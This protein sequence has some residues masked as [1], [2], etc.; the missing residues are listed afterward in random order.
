[1]PK[2][3]VYPRFDS[4]A[5]GYRTAW[6]EVK[7]LEARAH[8]QGVLK[9]LRKKYFPP[10]SSVAKDFVVR[11]RELVA[12]EE[13]T[14]E[15]PDLENLP[16]PAGADSF[17]PVRLTVENSPD[18][19]QLPLDFQGFCIHTLV[20]QDRLLAPGNPALGVVKYAGRFCVFANE[21]AMTEFCSEEGA[22]DRF[23][24]GV[25]DVCYK[26]PELIHLMRIHEDFPKSSLHSILQL[27]SGNQAAMMADA[28]TDTP[29][30][31]QESNIDKNYEWNEWRM[32][33]EALHMADIKRKQTSATQ[34]ALSHLRRETETQVY[35]QKEVATNT[36]KESGTNPPRWRKYNA[37]LRGEPQPMKVVEVK[38]DL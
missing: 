23:F 11:Y 10:V 36:T 1:V 30:H 16:G 12:A 38:F 29:L 14:E 18:F 34:T 4:V 33:R 31:M 7:S 24:G 9:D 8:L 35:L 25:R 26:H 21:K 20:T 3:Q 17:R 37:G 5:R 32:R 2:E 19:L 6:Q 27:T 28:S 22:P 15:V 13:D